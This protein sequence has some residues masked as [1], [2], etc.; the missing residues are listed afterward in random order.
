MRRSVTWRPPTPT[1]TRVRA[2]ACIVSPA[3]T[4]LV[5]G[6]P[7]EETA[8]VQVDDVLLDTGCTAVDPA[9][10]D[11]MPLGDALEFGVLRCEAATSSHGL[12][13]RP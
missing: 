13:V 8:R 1:P 10:L 7:T 4:A 11:A 12:S 2:L 3:H 6:W 5:R 9:S